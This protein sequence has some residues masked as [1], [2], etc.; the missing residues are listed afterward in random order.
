ML[1]AAINAYLRQNNLHCFSPKAILFDMD[2]VLYDSMPYHVRAWQETA[3]KYKLIAKPED[4]YLYEGRTGN[5]TLDILFRQTFGRDATPE[6]K[7]NIYEEKNALFTKYNRERPMKGAAEVLKQVVNAGW[8]AILVTGSGQLG[9]P[10][11]LNETYPGVFVRTKMV[12]A[13]DV[14]YGK[15][16]PEPYLAG[17]AKAGVK[18]CEAIVVENA[19]LGVQAGVA[20]GIFTIAVNTGPLPGRG[21]LEAG[22]NALFPDMQS[23]SE[24]WHELTCAGG[25]A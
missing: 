19:P 12:T 22:A 23:L 15:P 25:F 10:E 14:K 6:E 17:L 11:K 7:K 18:A 3:E 24:A 13:Y 2:G 16:H 5:S 21:L 9:L 8:Q 4:F 20:A 1:K